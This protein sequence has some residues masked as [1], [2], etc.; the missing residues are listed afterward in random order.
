M[1][2][3]GLAGV[4]NLG[5]GVLAALEQAPD[6]KLAAI[7]SRRALDM[8]QAP[9]YAMDDL[10]QHA[11]ELD[12]LILAGGS[13]DDLP[14]QTPYAAQFCDIVDS[15][16]THAKIPEH[17]A[18]V[19]AALRASGHFGVI[20]AGWDPGLFSL[21]RVYAQAALPVGHT[22]SFWGRGVSQG[23]SAAIRGIHGVAGAVQYTNPVPAAV[24]AAMEGRGEGLTT[25]DKHTRECYV[26][27][28]D[29]ADAA[30]V[31][32]AIVTMPNYFADYDTTVTFI[33]ADELARNHAGMPHG[34]KVVRNG[35][36]AEGSRH[37][38]AL[39]ITM[40]SNPAFTASLLVAYARA[41]VRM[42]VGGA[43]GAATVFDIPP[44]QLLPQDGATL[45]ATLL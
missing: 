11:G 6:M 4:G 18:A 26:V 43:I 38:V 44:A 10:A 16:D 28:E 5:R 7:F 9:I 8:A 41:V 45:R 29:G 32:K 34:G 37:A 19:D 33:S 27:L 39:D 36:T 35:T 24:T 1:I 42:R 15:F 12:V 21:M 17:F 20:S 25:R 40:E 30:A 14:T 2:R 31:E 13:A 3:V 22:A 23:H